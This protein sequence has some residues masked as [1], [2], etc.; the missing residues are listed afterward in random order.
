MGEPK[1]RG[2]GPDS[3]AVCIPQMEG[4]IACSSQSLLKAGR[5]DVNGDGKEEPV[6]FVKVSRYTCPDKAVSMET[7]RVCYTGFDNPYGLPC[8]DRPEKYPGHVPLA[9]LLDKPKELFFMTPAKGY[10]IF[11]GKTVSYKDEKYVVSDVDV[12]RAISWNGN[13]IKFDRKKIEFV[14]LPLDFYREKTEVKPM[15]ITIPLKDAEAS[16][17][18]DIYEILSEN[19]IGNYGLDARKANARMKEEKAKVSVRAKIDDV[20]PV[21]AEEKATEIK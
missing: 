15:T 13:E 8:D 2:C 17:G 4:D 3:L 16:G 1:T 20:K 6:G 12:D 18:K 21:P 14:L 9:G 19:P 5:V 11:I 10:K 7:N